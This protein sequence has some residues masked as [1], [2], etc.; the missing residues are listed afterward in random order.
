M[1]RK[2]MTYEETMA[3]GA[4]QYSDV[5][6][7]LGGEGLPG[8]FIQTGGMCAA[9]EVSLETG[10]TLLITD[11]ED[12]LAW[13]RAEHAGWAVGLYEPGEHCDGPLTY[14]QV[15]GSDTTSLLDL[16]RD[17]MF[18]DAGVSKR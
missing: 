14:A 1:T 11:A 8:N 10:R 16:I 18:R 13:A 2:M 17:V 5:L 9:I 15:D 6:V 3:W 12:S 7:R 4:G